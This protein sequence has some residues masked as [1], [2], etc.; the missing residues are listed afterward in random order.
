MSSVFGG[1][2]A[3][4]AAAAVRIRGPGKAL[5]LPNHGPRLDIGPINKRTRDNGSALKIARK[6]K[7][8][9][10]RANVPRTR[11]NGCRGEY[12]FVVDYRAPCPNRVNIAVDAR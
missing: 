6:T 1:Y 5:R 3:A 8:K 10:A 9:E 2:P 11:Y 7:K 12:I 4:V